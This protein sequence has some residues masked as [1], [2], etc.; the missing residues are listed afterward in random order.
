MG[1]GVA[2]QAK[3]RYPMWE[4]VRRVLSPILDD[5]FVVLS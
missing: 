1:K 5:R 2:L 3:Q 4:D